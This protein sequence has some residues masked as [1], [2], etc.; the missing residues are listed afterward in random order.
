MLPSAL[1]ISRAQP[2]QPQ[3]NVDLLDASKLYRARKTSASTPTFPFAA[4]LRR[5]AELPK[6]LGRPLD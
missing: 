6:T 3:V 2:E 1:P 4:E 5:I